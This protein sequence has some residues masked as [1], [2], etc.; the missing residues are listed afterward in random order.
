[1]VFVRE[2][3]QHQI[4]W[5]GVRAS[6]NHSCKRWDYNKWCKN[7]F[8]VKSESYCTANGGFIVLL[9]NKS[10]LIMV[11]IVEI[12]VCTLSCAYWYLTI[13]TGLYSN[14]LN[15]FLFSLTT[16][17]DFVSSRIQHKCR[18]RCCSIHTSP[19]RTFS[20]MCIRKALW[21]YL[22]PGRLF[23]LYTFFFKIYQ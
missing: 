12:P 22:A 14:T 19:L 21:H 17:D 16:W 20:F 2:K 4:R 6:A 18:K 23:Y 8:A 7:A 13:I 5:I 3:L 10:I 15:A 9:S 11:D 1:M